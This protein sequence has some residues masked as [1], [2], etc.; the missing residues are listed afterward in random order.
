[1]SREFEQERARR[2]TIVF[3]NFKTTSPHEFEALVDKAASVAKILI[4]K[5]HNVGFKTLADAIKPGAGHEQLYRIL[6]AL[7]L[8]CPID[9]EGAAGV[10]VESMESLINYFLRSKG[11]GISSAAVLKIPV[12]CLYLNFPPHPTLSPR[13]EEK[14]E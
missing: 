10:R 4:E 3:D 5:G 13:G 11:T 1:M 14:K 8:I 6:H 2:F 12:T 7:A 9:G